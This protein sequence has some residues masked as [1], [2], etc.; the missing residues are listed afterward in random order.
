MVVKNIVNIQNNKIDF[1]INGT[2]SLRYSFRGQEHFRLTEVDGTSHV[3]FK[4]QKALDDIRFASQITEPT[5][6]DFIGRI[7]NIDNHVL[8]NLK[9][10]DAASATKGQILVYDGTNWKNQHEQGILFFND[11]S[12]APGSVDLRN[13]TFNIIGTANEI[14]TIIGPSSN[15]IKIGLPNS[16]I[17]SDDL[18]VGDAT[19]GAALISTTTNE[20]AIFRN[21]L[22][23]TNSG[24]IL[25]TNGNVII[26]SE[27]LVISTDQ[28]KVDT[29]ANLLVTGNATIDG[30]LI[31][32]GTQT[33]LNTEI[34]LIEDPFI[35]LG[36]T[37]SNALIDTQNIGFFGQYK[38]DNYAG[39]YYDVIAT[40]FRVF[41][42]LGTNDY[43]TYLATN[44]N[45]N[46]VTTNANV[47]NI[48]AKKFITE[49]GDFGQ[50]IISSINLSKPNGD[51]T[52]DTT[53][54]ITILQ[55]ND[56]Y[57]TGNGIFSGKL[58]SYIYKDDFSES[59][60]SLI[61]Y[62]FH[63]GGTNPEQKVFVSNVELETKIGNL[64]FIDFDSDNNTIS[65]S[66]GNASDGDYNFRI[67][68]LP[69]LTL[70]AP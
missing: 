26:G 42:S 29:G 56:V 39:L 28:V 14:E 65:A 11:D 62:N 51:T 9:N 55:S 36:Y 23:N 47:A 63:V 41:D 13:Q 40:A 30:N 31:V 68:L 16:V 52:V 32:N 35:E 21:F 17:I 20:E 5:D 60:S 67:R 34:K 45:G 61:N 54:I 43:E 70:T 4:A 25:G 1:D 18:L 2:N 58:L 22:A 19:T 38:A 44:P 46:V 66:L 48:Q 6:A 24:I 50:E 64:D 33:I 10:V 8:T 3:Q 59:A 69:I 49:N 15:A 12:G 57:G 53:N 27:K 37:D 7:S